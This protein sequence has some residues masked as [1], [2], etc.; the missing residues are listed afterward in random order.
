MAVSFRQRSLHGAWKTCGKGRH[1]CIVEPSCHCLLEVRGLSVRLSGRSWAQLLFFLLHHLLDHGKSCRHLWRGTRRACVWSGGCVQKRLQ[2][3][4]HLP[5]HR[6]FHRDLTQ[7]P[8]RFS[9]FRVANSCSLRVFCTLS[10][11]FP[12]ASKGCSGFLSFRALGV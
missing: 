1:Y 11:A 9:G 6:V 8:M 3:H 12:A 7:T 10:W 2:P 4:H 5:P